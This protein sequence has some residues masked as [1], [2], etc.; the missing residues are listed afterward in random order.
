MGIRTLGIPRPISLLIRCLVLLL[1]STCAGELGTNCPSSSSFTPGITCYPRLSK[2]NTWTPWMPN[3]RAGQTLLSQTALSQLFFGERKG[4]CPQ[5][6]FPRRKLVCVG[7]SAAFQDAALLPEGQRLTTHTSFLSRGGEGAVQ[8]CSEF[9]TSLWVS[10]RSKP[11]GIATR[12]S[13]LWGN[14]Y[15]T[16][17]WNPSLELCRPAREMQESHL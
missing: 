9:R 3:T 10:P 8:F 15:F 6:E 14:R 5:A 1:A 17:F 4:C 11:L 7:T 2:R 12:F 16:Y 13:V